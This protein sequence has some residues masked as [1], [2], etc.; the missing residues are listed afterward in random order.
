MKDG[1]V[2]RSIQEQRIYRSALNAIIE[3]ALV[4]LFFRA[5][6]DID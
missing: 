4:Y 3:L 5:T 6:S 1:S 2:R